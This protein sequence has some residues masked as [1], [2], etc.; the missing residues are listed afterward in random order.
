[1]TRKANSYSMT[2]REEQLKNA[3]IEAEVIAALLTAIGQVVVNQVVSN[4][5]SEIRIVASTIEYQRN[6]HTFHLV[7]H[8][9][10]DKRPL[11]VFPGIRL[12]A[13]EFDFAQT[14]GP[15]ANVDELRAA[16][17]QH[18]EATCAECHALKER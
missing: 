2:E 13:A 12:D 18:N 8:D 16:M 10:T 17:L 7:V 9:M 14:H 11:S 3:R 6:G 4:A 15:F 5:P 1:M